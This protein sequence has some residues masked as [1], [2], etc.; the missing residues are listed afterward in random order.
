MD[1]VDFLSMTSKLL[2]TEIRLERCDF[3][4]CRVQL[5]AR[6]GAV[7]AVQVVFRRA[8]MCANAIVL[9]ADPRTI[10]RCAGEWVT[11][12]PDVVGVGPGS[13]LNHLP[14]LRRQ[15]IFREDIG[16]GWLDS[17][18][19]AIAVRGC[20]C[21]KAWHAKRN[22]TG[23]Q[24]CAGAASHPADAAVSETRQN[25]RSLRRLRD[26]DRQWDCNRGAL[27]L[28]INPARYIRSAFDDKPALFNI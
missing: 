2:L 20:P 13:Q 12:E 18:D 23:E 1:N 26:P 14:S 24:H 17:A 5:P 8:K 25:T 16:G 19:L 15:F 6:T 21:E 9:L 27:R 3:R 11:C 22:G 28:W 7:P 10:A 4:L